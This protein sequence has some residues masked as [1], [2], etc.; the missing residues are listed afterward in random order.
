MGAIPDSTLPGHKRLHEKATVALDRCQEEEDVDFKESGD[1]GTLKWRI[2]HSAL[3]MGNLRDGGMILVGVAETSGSWR[4]T[5]VDPTHLASY[6][7]DKVAAH[8]N[9]YASPHIDAD[10]VLVTHRDGLKYLAISIR[11]FRDTPIVCKKNG[12]DRSGIVEGRVYVRLPAPARTTA[13]TNAHQ[14]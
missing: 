4:L 12:P 1:W 9:A 8:I 6:D 10:V 2:T 14:M 13:I 11:E 3:G 5:G 7:P